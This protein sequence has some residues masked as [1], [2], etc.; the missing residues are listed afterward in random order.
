MNLVPI[1]TCFARPGHTR[2]GQ[3]KL[4][5]HRSLEDNG[6]GELMGWCVHAKDCS[7]GVFS[8]QYSMENNLQ[9]GCHC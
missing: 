9:E 3:L 8:L 4:V 1:P 2:A 5:I 6:I 7:S